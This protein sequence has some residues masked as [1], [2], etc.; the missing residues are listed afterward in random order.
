MRSHSVY[1]SLSYIYDS[2]SKGQ[3]GP[4]YDMRWFRGG[5]FFSLLQAYCVI[6]FLPVFSVSVGLLQGSVCAWICESKRNF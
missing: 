3:V 4:G 1:K 6:G 5:L 2:S